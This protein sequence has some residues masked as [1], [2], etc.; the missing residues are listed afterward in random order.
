MGQIWD[1]FTQSYKTEGITGAKTVSGDRAY[2]FRTGY[3][4]GSEMK[5]SGF[6]INYV[7]RRSGLGSNQQVLALLA[8][9]KFQRYF[10]NNGS[11]DLYNTYDTTNA[12]SR[13]LG[14]RIKEWVEREGLETS[15]IPARASYQSANPAG[16]DRDEV[17]K[18]GGSDEWI[19]KEGGEAKD[20]DLPKLPGLPGLPGI[21]FNLPSFPDLGGVKGSLQVT[22]LFAVVV[23]L[24]I[25]YMLTGKGEKGLTV[26]T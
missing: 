19:D 22:A 12:R 7:R 18:Y 6:E 24:I 23:V 13:L 16:A 17:I 21:N 5:I 3:G 9:L 8:N 4:I 2:A 14:K 26:V 15:D 1:A 11:L 25:V 10:I 20:I